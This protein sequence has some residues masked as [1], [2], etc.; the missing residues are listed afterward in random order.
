MSRSVEGVA[1]AVWAVVFLA[2][3]GGRPLLGQAWLDGGSILAYPHLESGGGWDTEIQLVNTTPNQVF[4][5]CRYVNGGVLA[6]PAVFSLSLVGNQ[7]THW[8]MSRGRQ[9][10]GPMDPCV[11]RDEP[12]TRCDNAGILSSD[13]PAVAAEFRGYMVCVQLDASGAPA[14]GNSLA[15]SATLR[16]AGTSDVAKYRAYELTGLPENDA[17]RTL[18]LGGEPRPDCPRGAEYLGCRDRWHLTLPLDA[19]GG[20]AVLPGTTAPP[21]ISAMSCGIDFATLGVANVLRITAFNEL[22]QRFSVAAPFFGWLNQ[23]LAS[24]TFNGILTSQI[25]GTELVHL[26]IGG[27]SAEFPVFILGELEFTVG[28]G[29][30]TAL[31]F[32]TPRAAGAGQAQMLLPDAE[33]EVAR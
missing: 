15:G 17:D 4:A 3:I 23:P 5:E 33:M 7:S 29:D 11:G 26:S 28:D 10:D 14:S 20:H 30:R 1:H 6:E 9:T 13:I 27:D 24:P 18:C 22:E 16:R 2:W 8:A 25:L 31:S 21:R 19:S 12:S 32:L